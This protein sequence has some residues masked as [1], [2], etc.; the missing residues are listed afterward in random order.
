MTAKAGLENI[1]KH[2]T[3]RQASVRLEST[4]DSVKLEICDDGAGFDEKLVSSNEPSGIGLRSI[5]KR[6]KAVDGELMIT[7]SPSAGTCLVATVPCQ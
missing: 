3:A 2:A 4:A 7:S 5:R 1:L 6:L